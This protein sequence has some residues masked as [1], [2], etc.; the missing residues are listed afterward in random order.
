LPSLKERADFITE[1]P[2]GQGVTELIDQLL[3]NN[4]QPHFA[5]DQ[6]ADDPGKRKLWFIL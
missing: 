2:Y 1:H 6:T 5:L 3:A 4:F